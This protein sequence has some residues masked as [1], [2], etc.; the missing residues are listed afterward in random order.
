MYKKKKRRNIKSLFDEI[1][2]KKNLKEKEALIIFRQLIDEMKYM[3]NMNICH[4]TIK[5]IT[6]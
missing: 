2:K 3:H 5:Y 4:K 1:I 6:K